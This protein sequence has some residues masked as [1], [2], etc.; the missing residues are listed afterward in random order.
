M[1]DFWGKIV[2]LFSTPEYID[3]LLNGFWL[4]LQISFFAL[5][6]GLLLGTVIA[7]IQTAKPSP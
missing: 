7:L 3:A 5:T 4:T 2:E 6:I 1:D